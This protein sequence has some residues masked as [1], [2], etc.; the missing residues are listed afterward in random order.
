MMGFFRRLLGLTAAGAGIYLAFFRP[1][2]ARWGATGEEG[3]R[4]LPGDDVIP[5]PRVE[6]TRAITIAASPDAVWPWIAQMGQGRGGFYA[7]DWLENAFGLDLAS[8]ERIVPE[9]QPLSVGDRIPVTRETAFHV[10]AVEPPHVLVLRATLHPLTGREVSRDDPAT[11]T[12]FDGTWTFV[13]EP[14]AAGRTRLLVRLRADFE[15]AAAAAGAHL[16]LEPAHFL[17]ERKMLVTLK[18][19]AEAAPAPRVE[20]PRA[21]EAPESAW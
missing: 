17:M 7:Y 21:S 9:W 10:L 20:A 15:P 4:S 12:W 6:T 16:L 8:A 2:Q 13:L 3:R 11:T 5:H 19:R 14:V 1:R 18:A